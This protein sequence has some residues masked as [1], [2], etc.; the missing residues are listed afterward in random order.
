MKQKAVEKVIKRAENAQRVPDVPQ[1][2][3]PPPATDARRKSELI[4]KVIRK[5]CHSKLCHVA[6]KDTKKVLSDL[7][8]RKFNSKYKDL[9]VIFESQSTHSLDL[10]TIESRFLHGTY[11]DSHKRGPVLTYCF[12]YDNIIYQAFQAGICT[13]Q[14]TSWMKNH[15]NGTL[16]VAQRVSKESMVRELHLIEGVLN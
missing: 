11:G 1:F 14:S 6:A 8:G 15:A 4:S 10:Q 7:V 2:L 16:L 9:R 13:S 5:K 3:S 12:D